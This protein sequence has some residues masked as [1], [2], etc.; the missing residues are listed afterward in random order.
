L[1]K[2]PDKSHVVFPLLYIYLLITVDNM[3]TP[4][5]FW[6]YSKDRVVSDKSLH[7]HGLMVLLV[8]GAQL[9]FDKYVMSK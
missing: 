6:H 7:P 4:P 2:W 3:V 1:N 5:L 8:L 9:V